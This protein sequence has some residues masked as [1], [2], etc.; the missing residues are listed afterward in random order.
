MVLPQF[1]LLASTAAKDSWAVIVAVLSHQAAVRARQA[2][3][4]LTAEH[5]VAASGG[6]Y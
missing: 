4:G 5:T 6:R 1:L 2:R 3:G